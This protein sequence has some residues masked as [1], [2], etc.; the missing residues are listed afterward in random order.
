[1][2]VQ[3]QAGGVG[4]DLSAAAY[5][6]YYSTGFSLGDYQQSLSRLHRP[7]QKRAVTYIN[8]IC[9]D[10]ID[11]QVYASLEHKRDVIETILTRR[12]FDEAR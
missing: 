7:G 3:L 12:T 1:M 5:A 11:S 4:V 2:G 6:I 9:E 10:T 8:L